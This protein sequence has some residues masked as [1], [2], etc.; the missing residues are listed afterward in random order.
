MRQLATGF[1]LVLWFSAFSGSAGYAQGKKPCDFITKSDA[2]SILGLTVQVR[3]DNAYQCQ[4]VEPNFT[5]ALPPRNKQVSLSVWYS[6][7]PNAN[8]YAERRKNIA[9]HKAA[10]D[11]VKDVP[12][13]ADAAIWKWTPGGGGTLIAFKGGAIQTEVTISGIPEDAALQNAKTLAAKPL[14]GSGGSGY[15]YTGAPGSS[16]NV[17]T[18]APVQSP[19]SYAAAWMGQSQVVRGTVSRVSVDFNGSPKWLTIFFKES[20]DA[21]F[22]VCSP[23]P[24]MFREKVGELYALVGKTLEV[25]GQVERSMCAGKA[26]SIR[27]VDSKHYQ[28]PDVA[29]SAPAS[30]SVSP[31][32]QGDVARVGLDICN[33]GKADL[34]AFVLVKQRGLASTHI[35][36]RECAHV[37]EESGAPAYIGFA[38]A[39][40]HGQ[41]GAARRLDLLPNYSGSDNAP[42]KVWSNADQSVSVKRGTRDVSLPLQLLFN[43]PSA[44]CSTYSATANLPY[45]ATDAQRSAAAMQPVTT[46]CNSFDYTLNVV[47]YPDTRELAFEKK[48]FECPHAPVSREQR[49]AKQQAI[50]MMSRISP[51]AGGIIGQAAA[52]EEEQELKESLEGPPDYRHMNW[53]E[54]NAALAKVPPAK[55]RP[56][57]MPQYLVIRGTVSRVDVSPP[58]ASV[59]WVDVYFRES[60]EERSN[61]FETFYG[62][63]N[64]CTSSSDIFEEMF[65]PNFRTNMIGQVLEIEGEYQRYYCKGWRG[66]IRVT[67][68]HQVHKVAETNP[69]DIKSQPRK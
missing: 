59:H 47:A 45:G 1:V 15:A 65:G 24:D 44:V 7:T 67:L 2:E 12:G 62:A 23:Y 8:D 26:A 50:G 33:G 46:S 10:S 61:A 13:F 51:L 56:S 41:W 21:A 35:A 55:G 38:F 11:L 19:A 25:T 9:D 58:G 57:E 32:R 16:T 49:A 29:A 22:V 39:D 3:Q 40:S 28:V 37:Y 68:A 63:F 69:V 14:G 17:S 66:S 42:T 30:V 60:A 53:N 31:R 5:G 52:Q 54:M 48:C 36:P 34:D 64:T 43:P 6:A 27:V 18:A 20:P 4:F